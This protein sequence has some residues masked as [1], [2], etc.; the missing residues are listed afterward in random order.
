MPWINKE[1]CVGC[2]ICV[3]VCS[4][5]AISMDEGIAFIDDSKCIRCGSCHD[6]CPQ[7]AVRH[8]GEKIPEEVESNLVSVRQLLEHDYYSGNVERQKALI[9]RMKRYF[10]KEGKVAEKTIEQLDALL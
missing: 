3:N 1:M 7:N 5:G 10:K 6:V 8:D 2:E 4:V 9:E